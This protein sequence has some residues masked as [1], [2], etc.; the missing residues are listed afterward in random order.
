MHPIIKNIRKRL[1]KWTE[2]TLGLP[3]QS[4][5]PVVRLGSAYGG[6]ILPE[7]GLNADSICYLVGA[8]E[9]ISFD[10]DLAYRLRCVVHIIDPTPRSVHH[11]EEVL[12]RIKG[13]LRAT[14]L[15]CPDGNYPF[16]TPE[17]VDYIRLHAV[18]IW[19]EDAS[20]KF[21]KPQN[22]AFVS[23]SAVNLQKSTDFIELP[24]VRLRTLMNQLGHSYIDLLKLD[25]EGAEYTVLESI[26]NDPIRVGIL[27]IEFDESASHH[28]DRHYMDRI[29]S[30]LRKLMSSGFHIIAKER[31]CHNYTLIHHSRL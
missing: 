20:L 25:I 21:Y 19:N 13:G 1:I 10:L 5:F 12:K 11:V 29:R 4:D 2:P 7:T 15:T 17:L 28:F 22:P 9:D 14:C 30:I 3:V 27:C 18:G 6:W 24:A 26:L 31:D 8:G 23:H 16:Y